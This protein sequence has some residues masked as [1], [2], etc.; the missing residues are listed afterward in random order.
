ML[1]A[2]DIDI[3][4]ASLEAVRADSGMALDDLRRPLLAGVRDMTMSALETHIDS[5]VA[6]VD[7]L[8]AEVKRTRA[9]E[10]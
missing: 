3:I 6:M 7:D 10:S 2:E 9:L 8:L 1:T 5:L 4:E